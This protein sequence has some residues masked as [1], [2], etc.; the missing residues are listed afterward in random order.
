M[1]K[2]K[3]HMSESEALDLLC[4]IIQGEDEEEDDEDPE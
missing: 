4:N 2:M 1:E 3:A